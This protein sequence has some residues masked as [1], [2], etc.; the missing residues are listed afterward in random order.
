[1]KPQN[2]FERISMTK[3]TFSREAL[4]NAKQEFKDEYINKDPY[5]KHLKLTGVGISVRND[6]IQVRHQVKPP[7]KLE[8][9][10]KMSNGVPVEYEYIGKIRI[11]TNSRWTYL[12][13][14]V[15]SLF[16]GKK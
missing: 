7:K 14:F 9:P 8:L 15:A 16:F 11:S 4:L 10:V 3:K 6:S 13:K 12:T 2:V 1:M 5:K